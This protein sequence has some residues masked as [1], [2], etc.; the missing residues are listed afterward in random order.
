[1]A[2]KVGRMS[3]K[4]SLR[5]LLFDNK[6]GPSEWIIIGHKVVEEIAHSATRSSMLASSLTSIES[7]LTEESSLTSRETERACSTNV[8]CRPKGSIAR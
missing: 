3:V 8:R 2:P 5:Q 4:D 6:N 1:M 7:R